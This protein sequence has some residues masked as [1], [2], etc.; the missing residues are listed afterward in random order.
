MSLIELAHPETSAAGPPSGLRKPYLLF[1]AD[2]DDAITAKTAFGLRDW[3]AEDV[4]GQ[5]RL[6]P[7][8]VDL[9]LPELDPRAAHAAG[10]RSVVVGAAPSGGLL[11]GHWVAALAFAARV[12]LDVVS[13]LHS[14]L[15]DVPE[16]VAAAR[17]GGSALHDIRVPPERF[18]VATGRKR[19]GRRLLT[20]GADC[21]IGKKYTAL[22]IARELAHRGKPADFRATGQTGILIAGGGIPLDS[23]VSDFL[24]G[25][26]ESLSPD[27]A[28]DHWD[29]IEGQGS[30]FHPS[31]AGV[32]LGLLHGSQ[33]DALVLC[34]DPDRSEIDGCPGFPVPD[35]ATAIARNVEAAK[36]TNADAR[37][38]G[39]ALNTS[40]RAEPDARALLDLTATRFGLP[41]VD[42]IRFGAGA[43]VDAI[44]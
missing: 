32:S 44:A 3:I 11:P 10:A 26:A 35:I 12:G 36:L 13:G 19:S 1:I 4:V 15:R 31:Y 2:V 6:H 22:A 29:V 21:A 33:P 42:P 7:G 28:S 23:V 41:C 14:R 27:A 30:L 43:I 16:L 34:Y 18:A 9:G 39:I 24:A 8:A 20:V 17:A 25:A 37:C 40:R 38:V 5:W